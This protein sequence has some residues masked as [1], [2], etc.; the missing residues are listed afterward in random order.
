[1]RILRAAGHDVT[2]LQE[3]SYRQL[4]ERAAL[5]MTASPDALIVVGGDGMANL[6]ANLVAGTGVPLGIVPSGTGNDLARGLGIPLGDPEAALG[7]LLAALA[8]GP[9][10]TD[11]ARVSLPGGEVRWFACVLSAGFD[12]IVNERANRMRWP[13]GKSRYLLALLRELARLKPI[14]YR[15]VLD[16]IPSSTRAVLV[17][18][19]NNVS[20]GGG[21]RVTP[22][23][24]LDDGLLD[25]LVVT[26][27]SRRGFLRIFPRV[28]S[29]THVGDPHVS[30]HRAR[31]ITVE[32]DSIVAYADG[33][34]FGPLPVEIEVVPGC[35]RV[36]APG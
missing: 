4:Q 3:S 12:A 5:A 24:A 29:G 14:D 19:G 35:L 18:V 15:L 33:E 17:A 25:V 32:A 30:I 1:V 10:I 9:R 36:L 16:G 8:S 13:K 11:A 22:D 27:L 31:R 23:A 26:P 7:C 21:M 20:L 28:F 34:R 2:V 6:G